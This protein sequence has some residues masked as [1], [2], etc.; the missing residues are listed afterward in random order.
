MAAEATRLWN[1]AAADAGMITPLVMCRM[2]VPATLLGIET[3]I[4]G[5]LESEMT[6]T[7]GPT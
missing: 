3:A 4:G 1:P 2:A 5:W 6:F 7:P